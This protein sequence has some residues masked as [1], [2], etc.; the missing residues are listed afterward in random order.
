[1]AWQP[2]PSLTP[3]EP[4]LRMCR[5]GGL[6]DLKNEKYAIVLSLIQAGRGSCLLLPHSLSGSS[7]PR[8]T[9]CSCS[10]WAPSVSCLLPQ[11]EAGARGAAPFPT[12]RGGVCVWGRVLLQA[13]L[14]EERARSGEME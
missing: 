12:P 5:W 6:L 8:G 13:Q 11:D 1:M 10:A 2:L 7:C 3:E 4:F 9:D 14:V